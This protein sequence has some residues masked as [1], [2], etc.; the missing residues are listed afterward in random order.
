[1]TLLALDLGLKT[2]WALA[3]VRTGQVIASGVEP[4]R[5]NR[6]EGGGMRFLR[7]RRWLDELYD[8]DNGFHEVAYEEVRAHAGTDAAHCYGGLMATLTSW[9]EERELP[10]ASA[11]VATIKRHATGKG[12]ASKAA[13]I[14]ALRALGYHPVDDN[15]AD[16]IALARYWLDDRNGP[17]GARPKLRVVEHG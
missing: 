7:F 8:D 2:G 13:V 1:V 16:A 5:S 4:F 17:A 9:C 12:N 11:P 14:D 10:Y 15:E 6:W 3:E